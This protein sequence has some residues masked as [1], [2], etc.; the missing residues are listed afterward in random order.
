M[1]CICTGHISC[2]LYKYFHYFRPHSFRGV[3]FQHSKKFIQKTMPIYISKMKKTKC[4]WMSRCLRTS[5]LLVLVS[6]GDKYHCLLQLQAMP[7]KIVG[8]HKRGWYIY[9]HVGHPPP[10]PNW[11]NVVGFFFRKVNHENIFFFHLKAWFKFIFI[12]ILK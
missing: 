2:F 12:H 7:P 9:N 5:C 1:A 4:I 10:L 6:L 8:F 11:V 3:T